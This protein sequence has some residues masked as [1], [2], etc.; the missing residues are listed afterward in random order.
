MGYLL[1]KLKGGLQKLWVARYLAIVLLLLGSIT[2]N[3]QSQ[4]FYKNLYLVP[5]YDKY[6]GPYNFLFNN[7]TNNG[8][9]ID[10]ARKTAKRTG[11]SRIDSAGSDSRSIK[12][13]EGSDR[14]MVY[15]TLKKEDYDNPITVNVYNLLGKKVME[16]Y[17]GMPYSGDY[18]YDIPAG[19][20]PK[21]IYICNVVGK[22]FRLDGK[23]IVTSATR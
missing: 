16:V 19:E 23:F 8:T 14:F 12:I 13:R 1:N 10:D 5:T 21:G 20:L 15:L 7:P 6:K 3:L 2:N 18:P 11:E 9:V 4:L 17:R 22:G